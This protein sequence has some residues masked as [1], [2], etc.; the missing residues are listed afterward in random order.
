[1]KKIGVAAILLINPMTNTVQ[2][3]DLTG[4]APVSNLVNSCPWN[5]GGYFK[6]PGFDTCL[7]I[8]GELKGDVISDNFANENENRLTDTAAHIESRLS[9]DTK[10]NLGPFV[11]TTFSGVKYLW[12]QETTKAEI[13][14]DTAAI[15]IEGAFGSL[16]GGIQKSLY[17]GFTGYSGLSVGGEN[18]SDNDTLQ[19]T[20]LGW[21]GPFEF[22]FSVEDV[23]Y[24]DVGSTTNMSIPHVKTSNDYAYIGALAYQNDLF[25]LK[26][27]G[28]V[29]ELGEMDL[30]FQ[31]TT[32]GSP[33][34]QNYAKR[35]GS[36]YNYAINFNTEIRATD[37][38][39]V[40]FGAQAGKGAAGYT[41][42]NFENYLF[43][44]HLG[45]PYDLQGYPVIEKMMRLEGNETYAQSLFNLSGAT[46][47][48]LAGGLNVM[49]LENVHLTFDTSY[50]SFEMKEDIFE[51]T[52]TGFSLGSSLIWKPVQNLGVELGAG[53]NQYELKADLVRSAESGPAFD[54]AFELENKALQIG[55]RINYVFDP[56][57]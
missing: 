6:L 4:F 39:N 21:A 3:S 28:S 2:A 37:Y 22:G 12:D 25:S 17:T 13:E 19:A 56:K 53:F 57:F 43:K 45:S 15:R 9:F 26:L 33:P 35:F 46:S 51:L 50:Q 27:S 49:L 44:P 24:K 31:K 18:W 1:M 5:G 20:L 40:S 30:S 16:A 36:Q 54:Y 34:K 47:Y 23:V 48:T 8:G 52:G 10:T 7:K 32:L 42:F 11:L 14:A 55:T 41:G 38:V 29:I